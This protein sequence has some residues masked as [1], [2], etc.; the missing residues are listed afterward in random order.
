[1]PRYFEVNEQLRALARFLFESQGCHPIC[2]PF[3]FYLC[4]PV[5]DER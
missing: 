3:S 2:V 5:G 1:M 4:S